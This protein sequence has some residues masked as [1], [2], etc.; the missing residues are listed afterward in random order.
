MVSTGN[1]PKALVLSSGGCDSTVCTGLAVR[2]FG[3]ENTS[4]VSMFYGQRH[5]KELDCAKAVALHYGVDHYEIDLAGTHILD[6]STCALLAGAP[7][8]IEHST[9][10]EQMGSDARGMANTYVPFRNGLFLSAVAA[11]AMSI[12]P[13]QEVHAY[14]GVHADEAAGGAYA[15][16]SP[17]F[18]DA[19]AKAISI[20]TYGLVKL[21]AP[22]AHSNKAGV[23]RAGL[24]L[25]VPFRLT[26]SCYEGGKVQC[27]TCATC[28][29]RRAAFAANGVVDPVPYAE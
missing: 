1:A 17:E 25:D 13:Q 4:T 15:D 24:E 8:E 20:G 16:C 26:W 18:V 2:D 23:V 6:A 11:L 7:N 5:A 14:I 10:A 28:L 22:F 3:V 12:Y 27:G 9:Y 21:E 29:D 19:M